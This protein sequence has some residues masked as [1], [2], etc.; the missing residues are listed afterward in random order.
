[1]HS[2]PRRRI[3]PTLVSSWGTSTT[4]YGCPQFDSTRIISLHPSL[5]WTGIPPQVHSPAHSK[6]PP[7]ASAL[8][9]GGRLLGPGTRPPPPLPALRANLVA[10]GQQLLAIHIV[11]P[12]ALE[13]F[14]HS[15]CPFCPLCTPTLSLNPTLTLMPTPTLSLLLT[16]PPNL[17]LDPNPN[18]DR[19]LGPSWWGREHQL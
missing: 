11:A 15:P 13:K 4:P 9:R 5:V 7:R 3:S 2:T 19:I 10:K 12:K 6:Q 18:Q 16:L 14:F 17:S 8:P 1:M